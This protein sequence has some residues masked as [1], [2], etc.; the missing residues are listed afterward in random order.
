MRVSSAA[1]LR[2][3]SLVELLV[4]TAVGLLLLAVAIRIFVDHLGDNRRLL[5]ETRL[6]QDLRAATDLVVRDLRRAGHWQHAALGAQTPPAANPYR[7]VLPDI[8]ASSSALR[9][10][11]SRDAA[12]N[13]AIDLNEAT[14]FRLADATIQVLSGGSWQAVTDPAAV[15]ITRFR[16]TPQRHCVSLSHYCEAPDLADACTP[17]GADYPRLWVRR[18]DIDVV[19]EAVG[20]DA[21]SVVRGLRES[22]RVRNDEI[23]NPGGCPL[24]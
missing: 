12:E 15:R 6:H 2:G 21:A 16:V 7:A 8:A 18:Y 19:G 22:V 24:P 23:D 4:G 11:Y 20:I 14:G 17:A 9:Y 10:S 1:A 3:L 13:D 5:V